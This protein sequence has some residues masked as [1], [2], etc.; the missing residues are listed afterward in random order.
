MR[1][2]NIKCE[3]PG[4]LGAETIF[5][6]S[7]TP[8]V[9][10]RLHVIFDGWLGGEILTLSSCILVTESLR[11]F[12][13]FNYSGIAGYE[14]FQL[15]ESEN[16]RKLQPDVELPKFVRMKVGINSFSDD[17]SLVRYDGLYNQLIISEKAK[18]ALEKF[19]LGNYSI[20]A[21]IQSDLK[22]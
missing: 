19:N 1:F 12:L 17:F 8:W 18:E 10:K 11:N 14:H 6:K 5:D 22:S 13:S 2:Y 3:V 16:F 21:A 20:E 7:A 15:E 9:I 4:S